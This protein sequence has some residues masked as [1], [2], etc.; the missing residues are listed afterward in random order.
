MSLKTLPIAVICA[1]SLPSAATADN[2]TAIAA[3]ITGNTFEMR[4]MGMRMKMTFLDG[5]TIAMQTPRGE[6]TGTWSLNGSELCMT[7]PR[8]DQCGQVAIAANGGLTLEN[9][10]TLNPAN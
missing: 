3:H 6:Q 10:Q 9:G 4:R 7:M 2:E 1:L 8:G 5:G